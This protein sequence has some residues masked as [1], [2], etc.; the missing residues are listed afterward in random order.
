MLRAFQDDMPERLPIGSVKSGIGHAESA[1]GIAAVT[2]VLLQM[3][4]GEL[5]PSLHADELN[6]NVNFA[7]TPFEVQRELAPWPRRVLADGTERPRTAGVSSFGAGGTNAHVIL[8]KFPEA[9]RVSAAPGRRSTGRALRPRGRPARRAGPQAC[10][11]SARRGRRSCPAGRR[12]DAPVGPRGHGAPPCR[13]LR[14]PCRTGRAPGRGRR[15]RCARRQLDR[16]GRP[17][18][19]R[20]RRL[21]DPSACAVAWTSGRQ[22]DWSVLH[23]GVPP[24][25]CRC[26]ATP[27]GASGSGWPRRTPNWRRWRSTWRPRPYLRARRGCCW[28]PTGCPPNCPHVPLGPTA[29]LA[30]PGTEALVARL[31]AALPAAEVLTPERLAADL[32]DPGTRWDRFDAVID[33]AGCTGPGGS[34]DRPVLRTWL[35][36][37][38]HT[39]DPEQARTDRPAGLPRHGSGGARRRGPHRALPHAAERVPPCDLAPRGHGRV[40][41]RRAVPPRGRRARRRGG[42]RRSATASGTA[43][44]C[45]SCPA[46]RS[47]HRGSPKAMCCG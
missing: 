33:L 28:P 36:W 38:Q 45:A 6:P 23:G 15:G 2:K 13:P 39:V 18:Q 14:Q 30:A 17:A 31:V 3:R 25:G 12:L 1:A 32:A 37:L 43:R 16:G 7:A 11:A 42:A 27:S 4:H 9:H 8:Q 19:A 10:H 35:S 47:A 26:P 40:H 44:C 46:H 20:S 22:V 41:G 34:D 24:A 21:A 5:A 29:V